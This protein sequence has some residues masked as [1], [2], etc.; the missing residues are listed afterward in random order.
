[1]TYGAIALATDPVI[2]ASAYDFIRALKAKYF[3]VT[4]HPVDLIAPVPT[5]D[6]VI[7]RTP[8]Q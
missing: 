6:R 7:I 5:K 8:Q 1:M 4:V 2:A 3:V